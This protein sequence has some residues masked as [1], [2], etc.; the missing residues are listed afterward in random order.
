MPDLNFYILLLFG[1][2][3]IIYLI[4]NVVG[5]FSF[6]YEDTNDNLR[7]IHSMPVIR[8]GSISFILFLLL[9]F[10]IEDQL[11]ENI[12]I[13]S[14][15]CLCIG[16]IEDITLSISYFFRFIFLFL[17]ILYFVVS[18]D[19]TID[20]FDNKIFDQFIISTNFLLIVFSIISF[21]ILIN[22]FNFIDGMNGLLLGYAIIILF[23]FLFKSY[24]YS[25]DIRLFLTSLILIIIPLAFFNLRHGNIMAGDGGAY[26][27]GFIIGSISIL[28]EKNQILEAFEIACY[29]FYPATELVFTF[30]R[31]IF[32]NKNPFKPDAMH[33]HHL[34][35]GI[36]KK[37]RMKYNINI[38]TNNINNF[39]SGLILLAILL[40]FLIY[41]GLKILIYSELIL[42]LYISIYCFIYFLLFTKY[43]KI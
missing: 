29:L 17:I 25:D 32:N 5:T 33:L 39:S 41:E 1:T 35:Y 19:F 24:A 21:L 2:F 22:G 12:I 9:I 14:Y 28:L 11:L 3:T 4:K 10:K 30:F 8:I 38:S 36:I 27:L 18:N 34:L 6:F 40:L 43:Q 31:R 20:S 37:N 16:L 13:F 23:L 26:F 7:K 42:I 15:L